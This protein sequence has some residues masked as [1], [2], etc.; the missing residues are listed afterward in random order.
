L[1]V[2]V[3]GASGFIGSHLIDRLLTERHQVTALVR[4]PAVGRVL[5]QRGV[6]VIVGDV[7]DNDAVHKALNRAEVVFNLA[8]A[9]AHG[10]RPRADVTAV[11]VIG[12]RNVARTATRYN[13]RM[14]HASSTAIYGS[15]IASL[16]AT[17]DAPPNPDSMYAGSKLEGEEAV[18]SE[19]NRATVLRISAVL[20]ARCHSWLPLFRSAAS[21]TLRL[22][23][24]GT[25]LHHPVDVEDVVDAMMLCSVA[26]STSGRTYNVAGPTPVEIRRLVELMSSASGFTKR[27][28]RPVPRAVADLYI[29]LGKLAEST[30]GV[31][32]PRV[33]SALFLTGNRSFDISRVEREV[34]FTPRI[35]IEIAVKRTAAF[36][37]GEGKL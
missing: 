9:K 15:R 4:N 13:A 23:G 34:G 14:I 16:P 19:C 25:N 33:E 26:P 20:G 5:A 11:N 35:D 7:S 22:A 10:T 6:V 3:T 37:R 12:A 31:R 24:D 2:A 18:R 21:G 32:L 8:R 27:Q 1:K 28:S 30:F 36:Y 29:A 17:E